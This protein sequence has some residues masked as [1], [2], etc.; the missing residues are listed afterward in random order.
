M[1]VE[2]VSFERS[3][4]FKPDPKLRGDPILPAEH[5]CKV[6]GTLTVKIDAQERIFSFSHEIGNRGELSKVPNSEGDSR[7][8]KKSEVISVGNQYL[9]WVVV[10]ALFWNLS[11]Y[12]DPNAELAVIESS[13]EEL[14]AKQEQGEV[15]KVFF[16]EAFFKELRD[17]KPEAKLEKIRELLR[18][19]YFGAGMLP[20]SFAVARDKSNFGPEAVYRLKKNQG[21]ESTPFSKEGA[22]KKR[23]SFLSVVS[24]RSSKEEAIAD[25][26]VVEV[27][28]VEEEITKKEMDS[29]GFEAHM[30]RCAQL[31]AVSHNNWNALLV[32]AATARVAEMGSTVVIEKKLRGCRLPKGVAGYQSVGNLRKYKVVCQITGNN[33]IVSG[34]ASPDVA[35]NYANVLYAKYIIDTHGISSNPDFASNVIQGMKDSALPVYNAD[36]FKKLLHDKGSL[37]GFLNYY[38]EQIVIWGDWRSSRKCESK[39]YRGVQEKQ[40][41]FWITNE[42]KTDELNQIAKKR[43]AKKFATLDAAVKAHDE[44]EFKKYELSQHKYRRLTGLLN[45]I[46]DPRNFFA[47]HLELLLLLREGQEIGKGDRRVKFIGGDQFVPIEGASQAAEAAPAEEDG[48]FAAPAS[49]EDGDSDAMD[50]DADT[51]MRVDAVAA[52]RRFRSSLFSEG[53]ARRGSV[54]RQGDGDVTQ[55]PRL[56]KN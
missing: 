23:P 11:A 17:M 15:D 30:M 22:R 51:P 54:Q 29:D 44:N 39:T 49:V 50:V 18:R 37:Q 46:I 13:I 9:D 14:Y 2:L 52:R 25:G 53:Q 1:G 28:R 6:S 21:R 31:L 16:S 12:G 35:A 47:R 45:G 36:D 4:E 32:A 48:D 5:K 27:S 43:G 10:H 38:N 20:F 3:V 55:Q 26:E 19:N 7:D 34:F 33:S 24:G 40:D 41:G 56:H 8:F 42:L